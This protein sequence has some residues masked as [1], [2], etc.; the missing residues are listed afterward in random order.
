MEFSLKKYL[1]QFILRNVFQ[2]FHW[3]VK[4]LL[5]ISFNTTIYVHSHDVFRFFLDT[6]TDD[7]DLI[8]FRLFA[9]PFPFS[10]LSIH[11]A[12]RILLNNLM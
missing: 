1:D 3:R 8:F 9:F 2:L 5:D 10:R 4:L 7:K 6:R 11:Q 12:N